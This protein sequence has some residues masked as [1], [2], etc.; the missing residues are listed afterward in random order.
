[1][2]CTATGTTYPPTGSDPGPLDNCDCLQG[3]APD[4]GHTYVLSAWVKTN[5]DSASISIDCNDPNGTQDPAL[6]VGTFGPTGPV[7]EGWQRIDA[8]FHIPAGALYITTTLHSNPNGPVYFDDLRI[9]P[10]N[11]TMGTVVYD[12]YSLR[13]MA[14]LDA[15]NFATFYEYDKSG[16]LIRTKQETER[17][18]FTISEL[19]NGT[20][21]ID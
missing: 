3:F 11:A 20:A 10:F 2:F 14:D 13:K 19:R 1:M 18:I 6:F 15:N 8:T 7:I 12:P 16:A 4:P 9:H 21:D 17:G 5:G